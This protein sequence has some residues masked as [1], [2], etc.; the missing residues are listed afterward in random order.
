MSMKTCFENG[1][2][3]ESKRYM[4]D[5]I[6]EHWSVGEDAA[7]TKVCDLKSCGA[8]NYDLEHSGQG[9]N[10]RKTQGTGGRRDIIMPRVYKEQNIYGAGE[11]A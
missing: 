2:Q 5:L 8:I 9:V 4:A 3:Q 7:A 6:V 10:F 1:R 11:K